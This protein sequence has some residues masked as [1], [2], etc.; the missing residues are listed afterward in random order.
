MKNIEERIG[1][2]QTEASV[3]AV[4]LYNLEEERKVLRKRMKDITVE[5][6]T[7]KSVEEKPKIPDDEKG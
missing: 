4:R 2:I 1:K 6:T 7:L 3:L 5:F